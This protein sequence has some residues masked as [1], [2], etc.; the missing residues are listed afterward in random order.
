MTNKYNR[1]KAW[2]GFINCLAH[3]TTIHILLMT[4]KINIKNITTWTGSINGEA[5]ITNIHISLITNKYNVKI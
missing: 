4:N 2:T 3:Y 1:I 5:H